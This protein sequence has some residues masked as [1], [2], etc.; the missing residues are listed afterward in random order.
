MLFSECLHYSLHVLV[1]EF[2]LLLF[3][4]CN[5]ILWFF[6]SSGCFSLSDYLCHSPN[7]VVYLP[8]VSVIR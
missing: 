1:M 8:N 7:V 4:N 2:M 3:P 6:L 5:V